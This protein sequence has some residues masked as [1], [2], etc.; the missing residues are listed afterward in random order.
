MLCCVLSSCLSV[1]VCGPG[2]VAVDDVA[3]D[4]QL[5]GHENTLGQVE[6]SEGGDDGRF[7]DVC[8]VDV[9]LPGGIL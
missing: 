3:K 6:K 1:C 9:Y 4:L 8:G 2:P 7:G 5:G